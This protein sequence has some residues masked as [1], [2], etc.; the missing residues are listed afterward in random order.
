MYQVVFLKRHPARKPLSQ[1]EANRIQSAHMANI[2]A[3]AGRGVLVAAGPFDDTPPVISGVFFFTTSTME[4]ARKLAEADPT[5][6]ERRNTVEVMSWR[7]PAGIGDE[8]RRLHK[9]KPDTPE[10]MGVHPFLIL[11]RSGKKLDSTLM[12]KH[13]AYW[14]GLGSRGKIVA[15][16][17]AEGDPSAAGIVIFDRIPDAEA[18]SLAAADPAVSAGLLTVEA[19][20]WWCAANVFPR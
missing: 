7:G 1:E 11:R 4:E 2:H 10:G 9:E 12:A 14:A 3:M 20:R 6:T 19:H 17:A 15:A 8:Y 5:V 13:F 16:G 18:A